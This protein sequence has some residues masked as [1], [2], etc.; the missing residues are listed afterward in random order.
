MRDE[1]GYAPR[2]PPTG[3]LS[4]LMRFGRRQLDSR[5]LHLLTDEN[6]VTSGFA[7]WISGWIG[8]ESDLNRSLR[9]T[10]WASISRPVILRILCFL[11]VKL[12]ESIFMSAMSVSSLPSSPATTRWSHQPS[13]YVR[14]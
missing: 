7:D 4:D 1:S 13:K 2:P 10:S 6:E 11:R 8:K 5:A 14:N 12:S 3:R 9:S